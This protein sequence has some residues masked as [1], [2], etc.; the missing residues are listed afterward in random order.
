MK[1]IG[2][3]NDIRRICAWYGRAVGVQLLLHFVTIYPHVES[4][5]PHPR[6]NETRTIGKNYPI[7]Y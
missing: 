3:Q 6:I 2:A 4:S 1:R 5:L 7:T